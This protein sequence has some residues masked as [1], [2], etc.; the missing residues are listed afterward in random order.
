M[1][2]PPRPRKTGAL[3]SDD[4]GVA[5]IA[6][7]DGAVAAPAPTDSPV[8][9]EAVASGAIAFLALV[10]GNVALAFGPWFVR[11]ADTGPVA[12]GFWRITLAAP[13]LIVLAVAGRRD[14][15][16]ADARA[17]PPMGLKRWGILILAGIAF[18]GDLGSW[19]LGIMGTT[20][21]NATL[22]GNCATFIFPL[23][24]FIVARAWPTR[25]QGFALLLAGAGALLLLGRSY[26]LDPANLMGDALCLTA[27]ILYA[28]YFIIM[29]GVRERMP[30]MPALALSTVASIL[31]L[32]LFAMILRETILPHAWGPLLGLALVSQVLGQGCMIYALGKASPLMVGLTLLIQPVV[33][34]TIGWVI[35]G[36]RLGMIDWIGIGMVAAALVLVRRRPEVA[37]PEVARPEVARPEVAPEPGNHHVEHPRSRP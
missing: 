6:T 33:A 4:L 7:L 21:A 17:A 9:S 32:L 36:E 1:L 26:E 20:L 22:L 37:R 25:I 24:G 16:P 8:R 13:V 15:G 12:A 14:R 30:P 35:Y 31:P 3:K 29:A 5:A 10:I 27:G 2:A 34:A 11:M 19:H 18:A 23:Y 28:V